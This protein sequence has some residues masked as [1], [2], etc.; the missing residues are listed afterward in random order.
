MSVRVRFAPSPTGYLHIGGLRTALYNFLF[1]RHHGGR[2]V[3]RIEDTD[4]TRYVPGSVEDIMESLRWAGIEPDESPL[5]G[6]EFGPY[7]QSERTEIYRQHA[8]QLL[9][10]QTAYYAFDTPEELERMRE[11]QQAAGIAPHYDRSSMRNQ[12]TLG[13]EETRRLLAAGEPA[14]IRLK[15][16]L[17]G[18]VKF[19][20]R[21]RGT[22]VVPCKDI[23]D[24]VLLKSDGYPTYHLANVVDDHLMGITHVIRGEECLPSTPK[25][26]LLYQAF[27]WEPPEFAHLPLLLN[28]DRSKLSKRHGDV[29][30]RDYIAKGYF[31]EAIVNFIALLGWNP[32]GDRELYTME[33]LI[34]AFSL[35]RVNKAGA[36]FDLA[37]L[38]WM[39]AQYLK[40][41]VERDLPGLVA[42]L[43]PVLAQRGWNPDDEYIGRVI[44]LLHERVHRL[45]EIAEFG[46]YM[47]TLPDYD[48][49]FFRSTWDE[50]AP[51]TLE[52]LKRV[53]EATEPFTAA[54][55][56]EQM[57]R[58]SR[59][60]NIPFRQIGTLLRLAITGK[61]VGAG[62]MDT[63]ALLG[64][65]EVLRRIELFLAWS[66]RH[67][68]GD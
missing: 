43:R 29:A 42:Q 54:A 57:N 68:P 12:F 10:R 33:E 3:L 18:E 17:H 23:D 36:V 30:V 25:H 24:Q 7:V 13:P 56:H 6:G 55:L 62:M 16:P 14:T 44:V 40:Q 2:F 15:V 64:K 61:R 53:I 31:P 48:E 35:E 27:G 9:E 19:D 26:I 5:H 49:E 8:Q 20:D 65:A 59:E 60:R 4:R 66:T 37:K 47:F 63:M 22:I 28:P 45:P 52:Q 1:A 11:R 50:S 39:N 51:D 21:I 34:A 38:D 41:R 67:A 32:S 58:Y 46:A